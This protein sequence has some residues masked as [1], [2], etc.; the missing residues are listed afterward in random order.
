MY[1]IHFKL[2]T[3]IDNNNLNMSSNQ[4][5]E[6]NRI[7]SVLTKTKQRINVRNTKTLEQLLLCIVPSRRN[8]LRIHLSSINPG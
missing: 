8:I 4:I 2:S 5:L 3:E 1:V 6:V 7:K